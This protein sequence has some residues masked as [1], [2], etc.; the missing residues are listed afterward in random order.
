MKKNCATCGKAFEAR[1]STAKYCSGKCRVQAQRASGDAVAPVTALP[2]PD[3]R[4][5][6]VL[7]AAAAAELAGA[8]L[9]DSVEG[10][11]VLTLAR[12][13][14]TSGPLET[15]SAFAALTKEFR[16]ALSAAMAGAESAADP[17]DELR[18]RR[19]AKRPG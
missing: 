11:V 5:P 17:L 2:D 14:D 1:R 4:G 18:M 6:G 3:E 16:A 9:L 8:G 12:R 15:G 10:A 7:E 13:I 19:D